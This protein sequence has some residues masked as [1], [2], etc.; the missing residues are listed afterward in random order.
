MK[1]LLSISA[2]ALTL[3]TISCEAA[4]QVKI[5]QL[6]D[7]IP[8]LREIPMTAVSPYSLELRRDD[9]VALGTYRFDSKRIFL[10]E[11]HWSTMKHV[12]IHEGY[13]YVWHNKMSEAEQWEYCKLFQKHGVSP[14]KYGLT[15]C[16]ENFAEMGAY[17]SG[18]RHRFFTGVE[19]YLRD[20]VQMAFV[21]D[22]RLGII[23]NA[24]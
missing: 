17:V 14:S 10:Q 1:K 2:I 12:M 19:D 24:R 11:A 15:D 4:S 13:H 6:K 22:I 3:A 9:G 21:R 5:K 16:V 8:V 7:G 18:S 20:T 23:G